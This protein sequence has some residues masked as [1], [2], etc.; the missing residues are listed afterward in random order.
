M[1]A[2]DPC[3]LSAPTGTT[4][5]LTERREFHNTMPVVLGMVAMV[6]ELTI[7]VYLSAPATGSQRTVTA[8]DVLDTTV[9]PLSEPTCGTAVGDA[10]VGSAVGVVVAS[11]V[12]VA[13]GVALWVGDA[14]ASTLGVG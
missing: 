13:E 6:S 3:L 10:W 4:V 14:L 1:D 12:G 2:P 9:S 7:T 5:I 8:R 11:G